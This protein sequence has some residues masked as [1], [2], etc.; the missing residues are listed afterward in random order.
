MGQNFS[1]LEYGNY[2][3]PWSW[4]LTRGSKHSDLT[5][6][7]FVCWRRD[8]R[9]REVVATGGRLYFRC[10]FYLLWALRLIR[11]CSIT[12]MFSSFNLYVLGRK[13]EKAKKTIKTNWPIR[14]GLH[15]YNSF[16]LICSSFAIT[17]EAWFVF[18]TLFRLANHKEPCKRCRS[19][20]L[21]G[22][23]SVNRLEL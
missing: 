14:S 10:T 21:I 23:I 12:C 11:I 6:K 22:H 5:K 20:Q 8:G 19:R 17:A 9:L 16:L 18:L 1:S 7:L 4:S 3:D 13:I 15:H 2:R